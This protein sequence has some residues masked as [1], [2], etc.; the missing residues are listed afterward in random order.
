MRASRTLLLLL[1]AAGALQLLHYYPQLP[2]TVASHFDGAGRPNGFQSRSGFAAFCAAMLAMIVALFGGL[3]PLFRKF[4][5]R[6]FNL[7]NRDYWL[8]AERREET[9]DA[10]SAQMEW[11]GAATLALYFVVIQMVLET[12]QTPERSLDSRSVWIVLGVYL[13]F[14]AVWT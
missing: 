14:T 13:L 9:L 1:A 2:E 8:A 6:W 3:G 12:N 5:S 4:P 7:P 10:I 11:Y